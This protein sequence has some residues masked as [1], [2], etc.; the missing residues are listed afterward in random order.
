MALTEL[1]NPPVKLAHFI[2][3]GVGLSGLLLTY[4]LV[5]SLALIS[6]RAQRSHELTKAKETLQD[7]EQRFRSLFTQNPDAVFSLDLSGYHLSVNQSVLTLLEINTAQ[8][9]GRHWKDIVAHEHHPIVDAAFQKAL[10]G[11]AQRF[12]LEVIS[13]QGSARQLDISFLPTV[14]QDKV[15]GVYG[16]AKE[17]TALRQKSL[18][19]VFIN[20]AWKPVATAF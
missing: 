11:M 2:A 18:S 6:A 9:I 3:A 7:S 16:I 19:Y 15:V 1:P 17:M 20:A 14:V 13:Q 4:Q 5:F 12:D 8:I 10:T